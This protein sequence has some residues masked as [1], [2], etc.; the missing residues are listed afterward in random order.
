M[1]AFGGGP[2]VDAVGDI[3]IVAITR[4]VV[5]GAEVP[6]ACRALSR[7]LLLPYREMPVCRA[8]NR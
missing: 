4:G 8:Q 3:L 1:H 7:D 5:G 6:A 2:I